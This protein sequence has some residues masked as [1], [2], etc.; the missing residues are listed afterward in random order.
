MKKKLLSLI[1]MCVMAVSIVFVGCSQ[2]GLQ[3]NPPTDANVVSNGGMTVVKGDYLY[4]VN[5]YVDETTLSEYD[6]KSGKVVK[7]GIYRTKLN[8][9][10]IDKDK[11]GFLNNCDQV[12]SKVVGF[13]NGGFYIIDDSIYYATP[14]MKLNSDGEVQSSRV[15]FHKVNI[16]GTQDQTLYV[17]E[18]SEDNLDWTLYKVNGVV[19]IVT[20]VDSKIIIINTK[21]TKDIKTIEN[22]TSYAF[23]QEEDYVASSSRDGEL[24]N[25]I[26]YTRAI[27]T[28]D[29]YNG[30]YKGNIVGKVNIATGVKTESTADQDFTYSIV[31]VQDNQVYYTKTNSRYSGKA[32]LYCRDLNTK[33]WDNAQEVKLS[34]NAY[35]N[36]FVCDFGLHLVIADDSNGTYLLENGAFTKISSSQKTVLG[37]S[38]NYAYYVADSQ[39]Y[40]FNVRGEVVDGEI[41]TAL[42]TDDGI[43]H[44]ITNANYLDFDGQRV[45]VY[46][47]YTASN[48]DT[49]YYL[50]FVGDD[51]EKFVGKFED[52]HLPEKPEQD[53]KYGEDADVKYIPWIDN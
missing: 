33:D 45:Y 16:N 46:G 50:N 18:K 2:K 22:T 13:S 42:I 12:V 21:D 30:N 15:E 39:L 29:N 5:G 26:Y 24:Q 23:L 10:K 38:G 37:L 7:S 25:Y 36:Y 4:F 53:E 17:T 48:G 51:G 40:A 27:A 9:G 28:D 35:S 3:D 1:I 19:Y 11:D 44:Q 6:N 52:S 20:Y 14:Y 31:D 49:N 41:E 43:T 34:D 32:L 8:N 47:Q